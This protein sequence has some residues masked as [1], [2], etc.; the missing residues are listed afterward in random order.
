M[1]ELEQHVAEVKV[2]KL[3]PAVRGAAG[4]WRKFERGSGHREMRL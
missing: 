3:G 1:I 4:D 2:Q